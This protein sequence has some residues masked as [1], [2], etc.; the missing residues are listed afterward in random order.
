[1]ARKKSASAGHT[2]TKVSGAKGNTVWLNYK[3]TPED[4][5]VV[6]EDVQ[7]TVA[8]CARLAGLFA[9]GIDLTVR[10]VP[11]RKNYSAFA[12]GAA[13]G[14]SPDRIG[15]S[16]FGGT[17]WEA[18]AALLFK[19]DLFRQSPDALTAGSGSVGIG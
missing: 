6:R 5:V 16:A 13:P 18:L 15:I 12:V 4:I 8:L 11:E 14:D 2:A 7:D 10:Y 3:F 1:M 19:I 17:V 9:E